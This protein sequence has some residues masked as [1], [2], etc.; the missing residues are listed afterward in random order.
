MEKIERS[1]RG[2]RRQRAIGIDLGLKNLLTL[3]TGVQIDHHPSLPRLKYNLSH[4]LDKL[5]GQ[6]LGSKRWFETIR[7]IEKTKQQI[8]NCQQDYANKIAHSLCKHYKVIIIEGEIHGGTIAQQVEN[9][10]YIANWPM[11]RAAIKKKCLET[12]AVYVEVAPYF[13]SQECMRCHKRQKLALGDRTYHC[14]HC[15][16]TIDRDVNAANN[17]RRKGIEKLSRQRKT[18]DRVG[19]PPF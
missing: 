5:E 19:F 13:T 14:P 8:E 12:G 15:G 1:N 17:I 3:S 4:W 10:I 18:Q 9:D 16:L 11:L 6:E 2:R 7:I